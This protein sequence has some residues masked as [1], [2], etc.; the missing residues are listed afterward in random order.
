MR[1]RLRVLYVISRRNT[2]TEIDRSVLAERYDVVEYYQSGPRPRFTELLGKLRRADV[3]FAWFASWHSFA[4]LSLGQ[5]LNKPSVL[6]VGGF[7]TANLPDIH[8]GWQRPGIRKRV[9]ARTMS[10]ATRLITNSNYSLSEIKANVG[11]DP[12]RVTVVY[13]GLRDRFVNAEHQPRDP[14]VLTVGVVRRR[15]LIR[16]GHLPFIRTAAHL[17]DNT[18]ILAGGWRDVAIDTLRREAGENVVFTGYLDDAE[19]DALFLRA[20][21]YVQASRHEG[22][23]LSLAEAMLAGCVPVVTEAGALP[24][25]VGDVGIRISKP[26]PELIAAGV[27]QALELGQTEGIRARSR[28]LERFPLQ[29]RAEALWREVEAAANGERS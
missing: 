24:E 3:V 25:V 6:V 8:Y 21:V 27:A 12:R 14:L 5:L 11:M 18:F 28:I 19:L 22:F 4:A 17:P 9:A 7:D 15:N 1:P 29:P 16:K 23:G 20:A 2:F 26:T 10:L 13:H